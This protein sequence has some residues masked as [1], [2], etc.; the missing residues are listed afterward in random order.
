[1]NELALLGLFWL[2]SQKKAP[3]TSEGT[4]SGTG[5]PSSATPPKEG[6]AL[7]VVLTVGASAAAL[8]GKILAG[9]G[10]GAGTAA[11]TAGGAAAGTA[12]AGAAGVVMVALLANPM[13][14]FV[15]VLIGTIVSRHNQIA[16]NFNAAVAN[17]APNARAMH[18]YERWLFD[19][20]REDNAIP[21]MVSLKEVRDGRLDKRWA[22]GNG[23]VTLQGWRTVVSYLPAPP[24]K[25]QQPGPLGSR[26]SMRAVFR[27]MRA[28]SLVY[29][30][31]RAVYGYAIAYNHPG[32]P[33]PTSP[34]GW[35]LDAFTLEQ[36]YD[37]N[38]PGLGGLNQVPLLSGE[39][40]AGFREEPENPYPPVAQLRAYDAAPDFSGL[41]EADVQAA[42]FAALL[43]AICLFKNDQ[44][45]D[46]R[47]PAEWSNGLFQWL[48]QPPGLERSGRTWKCDPAIYGAAYYLDVWAAKTGEGKVVSL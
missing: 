12:A 22:E 3:T 21:G 15:Y 17:M 37:V 33:D 45:I 19:Q 40:E 5:S 18:E 31:E 20:F 4:G 26:D 38:E 27:R 1:M 36:K 16:K 29:L 42:R 8:G 43:D 34:Q 7:D 41:T 47:S 25:G 32:V 39:V 23:Y 46:L 6:S 9:A 44:T 13:A 10:G 30:R 28:A 2:L 48:G 35:S 24:P 11:A 14:W